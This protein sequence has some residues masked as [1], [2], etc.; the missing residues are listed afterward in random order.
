MKKG[1]KIAL[2]TGSLLLAG[3]VLTGVGN[4]AGGCPFG[5]HGGGY[6]YHHSK[7]MAHPGMHMRHG[8]DGLF[9]PQ[10][11]DRDF[12][13]DEIRTLSEAFLIRRGLDDTLK[14][15]EITPTDKDSYLVRIVTKDDSLVREVEIS[16]ATG[17]PVRPDAP[18]PPMPRDSRAQ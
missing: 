2:A 17:R 15:G 10:A 3:V 8:G 5:R 4:A 9:A 13:A 11:R 6:G 7:Q 14:V 18:K 12:T 16:K 1:T